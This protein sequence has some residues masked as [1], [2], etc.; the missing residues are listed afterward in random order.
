MSILQRKVVCIS[1]WLVFSVWLMPEDTYKPVSEYSIRAAI[2]C[3]CFWWVGKLDQCCLTITKC[4]NL[5]H[6]NL[7]INSQTSIFPHQKIKI[8]KSYV[9]LRKYHT[10]MLTIFPNFWKC[11]LS[12]VMLLNSLG[13]FFSSMVSL[14]LFQPGLGLVLLVW[15]WSD[16]FFTISGPITTLLLSP[17]GLSVVTLWVRKKEYIKSQ[18]ILFHL[19][20]FAKKLKMLIRILLIFCPTLYSE[21]W[22]VRWNID[23]LSW[24]H[25]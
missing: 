8:R 6:N 12:F 11:S 23:K 10:W 13:I 24:S 4:I 21:L 9:K 15:F 18:L 3:F 22:M 25:S 16:S 2:C 14:N 1:Y 17:D 20:Y 5:K 19:F 7:L